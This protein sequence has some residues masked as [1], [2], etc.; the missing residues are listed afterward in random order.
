MQPQIGRFIVAASCPSREL[1]VAVRAR[2]VELDRFWE[3]EQTK[4]GVEALILD[5]A[6]E[7][8]PEPP[9]SDQE[10]QLIAADVYAHIW[11]QAVSDGFAAVQ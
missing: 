7:H 5:Y 11:Q 9:F 8:F 4:A 3:K 10:K 6:Y 1:L 2:L